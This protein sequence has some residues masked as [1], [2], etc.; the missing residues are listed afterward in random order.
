[1]FA[2]R[3][4]GAQQ[5][6]LYQKLE[7]FYKMG[8]ALLLHS[9][10]LRQILIPALSCPHLIMLTGE[11][12]LKPEIDMD[13]AFYDE[14]FRAAG[15]ICESNFLLNAIHLNVIHK[16]FSTNHIIIPHIKNH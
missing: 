14:S 3:V 1:M 11:S 9:P 8:V 4:I 15:L 10:T 2:G 12:Y 13:I 7:K 16:L 6:S 5:V